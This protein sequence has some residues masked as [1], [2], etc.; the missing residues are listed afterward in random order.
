VLVLVLVLVP[1]QPMIDPTFSPEFAS[2]QP[3][4]AGRYLLMRELGRGGMGSVFLARDVALD[5]PVAIKLPLPDEIP[6]T[7][8]TA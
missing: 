6:G 1:I 3:V 8:T 4:V 7:G 5:R 2:P